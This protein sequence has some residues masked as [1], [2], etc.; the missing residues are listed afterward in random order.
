MK[1]NLLLGLNFI[2]LL[3]MAQMTIGQLTMPAAITITPSNGS[4]WDEITLTLDPS[5][6]CVPA[7]KGSVVGAS[8]V[9]MHSAA[10]LFDQKEDFE[11]KAVWGSVGID[12]DKEPKDGIH[13]GPDLLPVGD[14]TY[15]IT[16][17]PADFY[18]V[19]EGS[20][21]IG[22]TA[23]FN[24][25]SWDNE[26]KDNA[27]DGCGDFFIPLTYINPVPAL[28]FKL[29]LTYQEEL[30]NFNKD[31]GTAYVIF[32]GTPYEMDQLLEGIFPVAKY[33]YLITEGLVVGN[34]FTYKFKMDD[35][36]ESVEARTDI[37][38]G[39][40]KTLSHYF[41]D[42]LPNVVT[43]KFNV[44]MR[45]Y[46]RDSKFDAVTQFVDIAGELNGW[47]GTDYHLDDTDADSVYSIEVEGLNIGET[48]DYKYR[49]DG[50]WSD[51]TSEFP[52]GG[53]N[54]G[55]TVRTDGGQTN[56][57]YNNYRPG[58]VPL[59]LAVDMSR[60]VQ[61][62]QFDPETGF[63]DVAG[64]MNNWGGPNQLFDNS[65][66]DADI[67]YLTV[68]P[69]LAKIGD[70]IQYKF[71]IDG[72]WSD[73]TCEFPAGGPNRKLYIAD[74]A[75]G[76]MNIADTVWYNDIPLFIESPRK[77]NIQE[78]TIYPNPVQNQLSIDNTFEIRQL[79]IV[80]ILG[81]IVRDIVVDSQMFMT[82][83]VSDL[84]E[85]VYV[86]SIYGDKGYKG[87]ARFMIK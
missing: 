16:F 56:D 59:T 4:A 5:K 84:K 7:G 43:V 53:P 38:T 17:I 6:A 29:D 25:G 3:V 82:I 2:V 14:G 49:I 11:A 39:S 61:I 83:D 58:W 24:A 63:L 80:N 35:T 52:A 27:N 67:I 20:T 66:T 41:N 36:E 77:T 62:G 22:I 10:V 30:G 19:E 1:K 28:K 64:S 44:D 50:S 85:G 18:G 9:K 65:P 69:V 86:L 74:T 21:V 79:R 54:R 60:A 70:T 13:T 32:N 12:Y 26:C 15:S 72:S 45:Y 47:D 57:V 81:Q 40:Q 8:V 23:V 78:V 33:E 37:V 73:A 68:P 34:D 31:D 87:T 51:E 46:M 55:F 48:Y 76:V 71:R 75:G 42:E